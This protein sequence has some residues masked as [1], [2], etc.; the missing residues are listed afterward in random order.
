ML[1]MFGVNCFRVRTKSVVITIQK[2]N[3]KGDQLVSCLNIYVRWAYYYVSRSILSILQWVF[4]YLSVFCDVA[5]K[6]S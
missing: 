5:S 3:R 1:E 6:S 4:T 2:L